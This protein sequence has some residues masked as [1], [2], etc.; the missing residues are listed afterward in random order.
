MY[1]KNTHFDI[2]YASLKDRY[3]NTETLKVAQ[4]EDSNF[5]DK[6]Y[7][8]YRKKWG[9]SPVSEHDFPHVPF[10]IDIDVHDLC[11]LK[12]YHCFARSVK[13]FGEKISAAT[14]SSVLEQVKKHPIYALNIEFCSEPTLEIDLVKNIFNKIRTDCSVPD[15]FIHTNGLLLNRDIAAFL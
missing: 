12:C 6:Q 1:M 5:F 10:Q 3:L 13:R 8:K 11:N 15:L 9:K 4:I 14:I 7:E 2:G